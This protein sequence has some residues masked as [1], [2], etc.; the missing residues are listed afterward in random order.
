MARSINDVPLGGYIPGDSALHRL[1]PR[2][3]LA[4][5]IL[6]LSCVFL[7]T[8][9]A[10]MLLNALLIAMLAGLCHVGWRIWIWGLLRFAWMLGLVAIVN[11]LFNRYGAPIT[12]L[13]WGLPFTLEGLQDSLLLTLRVGEIVILSLILTFTTSPEELTRGCQRLAGPLKRFGVPVEEL[14]IVMLMAMRFIPLVQL[15]L[16]ATIEAQSARGVEFSR[17]SLIS[18]SSNLVAVLILSLMS[19]LRRA[20]LLATAMASRGYRPGEF[21]SEYRPLE[22]SRIDYLASALL[23]IFFLTHVLLFK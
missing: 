17:G 8:T 6:L 18:R 20:D 13:G 3:K 1:D 23:V 19:A 21:R 11:I 10:A 22:L 9:A 5:M 12:I 15:E 2:V 7:A 14:G 16:R 4:G